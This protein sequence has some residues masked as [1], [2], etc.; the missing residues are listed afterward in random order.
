MLALVGL[1]TPATRGELEPHQRRI[2]VSV[3]IA[4]RAKFCIAFF[5][6][7]LDGQ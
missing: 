2:T 7:M 4:W 3:G 1:L 6:D 5:A